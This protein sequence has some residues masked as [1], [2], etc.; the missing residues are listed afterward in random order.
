MRAI[1]LFG[2]RARHPWARWLKAGYRHVEVMV[3]PQPDVWVGIVPGR[4][5]TIRAGR[6]TFAELHVWAAEHALHAVETTTRRQ[7]RYQM[8]GRVDCVGT[9]CRLLG[10][11]HSWRVITPYQLYK[12]IAPCP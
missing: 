6:S 1:V 2:D 12:R 10:L 7:I 3:E 5:I 11:K 9:V 4:G 8:F